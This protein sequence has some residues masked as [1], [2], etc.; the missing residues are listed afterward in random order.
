MYD[1]LEKVNSCV[2]SGRFS[3][4]VSFNIRFLPYKQQTRKIICLSLSLI[5]LKRIFLCT[6]FILLVKAVCVKYGFVVYKQD[7]IHISCVIYYL[8]FLEIRFHKF[9]KIFQL[10]YSKQISPLFC[11]LLVGKYYTKR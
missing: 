2:C 5:G 9:V 11:L 10:L 3:M 8:W 7:I 1:D 6:S 4:D